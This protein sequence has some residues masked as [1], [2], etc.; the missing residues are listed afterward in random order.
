MLKGSTPLFYTQQTPLME[1]ST[2]PL[3]SQKPTLS[4]GPCRLNYSGMSLYVVSLP[5]NVLHH[6]YQKLKE[7]PEKIPTQSDCTPF[8]GILGL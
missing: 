7:K 3:Q 5:R 6:S 2:P 4:H 8:Q 1:M